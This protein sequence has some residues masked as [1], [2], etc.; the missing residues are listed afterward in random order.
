MKQKRFTIFQLVITAV[1][2]VAAVMLGIFLAARYYLGDWG[3]SELKAVALINTKFIGDLDTE[4]ETDYA[5]QGLVDGLDDRWSHYLTEENYEAVQEQSSNSYQGIGITISETDT[6]LL[7]K[8]VQ[9]GSP[10]ETAGIQPGDTITSV[11]GTS[12]AGE[13]AQDAVSTI[14]GS[15]GEELTLEILSAEGETRTCTVSAETIQVDPVSSEMLEGNI[16]YIQLKNFY[17]GSAEAAESAVAE[18]VDQG[19][20]AL[21]F[22]MRNNPG[23]YI[24]ELTDLL[25]YLMPEGVIFQWETNDDSYS[26]S[27][28]ASCV[29]LPIAV[30]VNASSYSAAEFFGAELQEEGRAVI[31]GEETS[32]KGYSQETFAMPN[33]GAIM[34]STGKYTTGDGVSLIGTG[35]TLDQEVVL[36]ETDSEALLNGELA[37]ED[38]EQLQAAL[39]LLK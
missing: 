2:A 28:D 15:E 16:G 19:A 39:E 12:A 36:D 13:S 10:A 3:I 32:G 5:L 18:L 14:R 31:V 30:I 1:A 26:I 8:T 24:S 23:G 4:T 27:S 21:V 9:E 34:L 33:G 6:G 29:D 37:H 17:S 25:D 22:D 7:V 20:Q 11:N 38:D 35:V